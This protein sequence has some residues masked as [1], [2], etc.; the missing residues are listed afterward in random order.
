MQGKVLNALQR[1]HHVGVVKYTLSRDVLRL[2]CVRYEKARAYFALI[3][4]IVSN[5]F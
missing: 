2:R 5:F 4:L 1:R 3:L